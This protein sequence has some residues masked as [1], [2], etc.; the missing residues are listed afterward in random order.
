ME[1]NKYEDTRALFEQWISSPP[2]FGQIT[3]WPDDG[4][5]AGEYQDLN[6]Q[7]AWQAWQQALSTVF[8]AQQRQALSSLAP[9]TGGRCAGVPV[10]EQSGKEQ[11]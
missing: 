8:S 6:V 7:L 1:T 5:R 11:P 9:R 10:D 3:R 2:Y 4:C